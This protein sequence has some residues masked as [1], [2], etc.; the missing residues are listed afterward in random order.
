MANTPTK[1]FWVVD[2]D[3]Y[4]PVLIDTYGNVILKAGFNLAE[5]DADSGDRLRRLAD[6]IRGAKLYIENYCAELTSQLVLGISHKV[7]EQIAD[8]AYWKNYRLEF[9]IDK[10]T[11]HIAVCARFSK[12][13][14]L[15]CLLDVFANGFDPYDELQGWLEFFCSLISEHA[16]IWQIHLVVN[17][18][19][20]EKLTAPETTRVLIEIQD[21]ES[22]F[23]VDSLPALL[24]LSL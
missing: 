20:Y 2:L 21:G 6:F 1:N 24:G 14:N 16:E 12:Y 7:V 23:M 19:V 9:L 10:I 17:R 22:I 18:S 15:T 8:L 11:G 13:P 4:E 5:E 3:K